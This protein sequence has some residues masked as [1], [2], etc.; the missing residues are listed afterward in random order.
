MAHRLMLHPSPPPL[1]PPPPFRRTLS[2][3]ETTSM[4]TSR[5]NR[6]MMRPYDWKALKNVTSPADAVLAVVVVAAAPDAF[7]PTAPR[8][9]IDEYRIITPKRS[10]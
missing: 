8:M 5:K 4:S 3:A 7:S 9:T 10:T 6:K 1:F 2:E